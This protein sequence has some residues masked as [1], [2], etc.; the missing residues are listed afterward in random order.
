MSWGSSVEYSRKWRCALL[1]SSVSRKWQCKFDASILQFRERNK[2][3]GLFN[4]E[5]SLRLCAKTLMGVGDFWV[6]VCHSRVY[7]D[8]KYQRQGTKE[9]CRI[10][11]L[12]GDLNHDEMSTFKSSMKFILIQA[13]VIFTLS[14]S[15]CLVFFF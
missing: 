5:K 4:F 7:E 15:L 11:I 12:S 9:N 3:L 10:I 6:S 8:S 13:I 2:K 1:L 14:L